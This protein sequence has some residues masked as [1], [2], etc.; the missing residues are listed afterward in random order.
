MAHEHSYTI[1]LK[2]GDKQFAGTDSKVKVQVFGKNGQ[3]A[4]VSVDKP[5][6]V[7][8]DLFERN[9][10]DQFTIVTAGNLGE[11]TGIKVVKDVTG[12]FADWFLERMEVTDLATHVTYVFDYNKWL[13]KTNAAIELRSPRI[14]SR[15]N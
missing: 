11:I 7:K 12:S 1:G 9:Q 5:E 10:M 14:E 4:L 3:S 13:N 15:M 8:W 2:T 6:G